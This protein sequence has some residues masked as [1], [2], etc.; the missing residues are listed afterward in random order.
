LLKSKKLYAEAKTQEEKDKA[1][2]DFIE[3]KRRKSRELLPIY[4]QQLAKLKGI[5]YNPDDNPFMIYAK[6]GVKISDDGPVRTRSKDLDR[7]R[8]SRKDARDSNDKKLDRL[9]RLMYLH[10]KGASSRK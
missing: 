7:R 8:K 3:V 9:G 6:S 10:A 1:Y 5:R 4:Y 2:N